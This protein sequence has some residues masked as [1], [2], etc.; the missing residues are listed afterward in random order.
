MSESNL[1]FL[2]LLLSITCLLFLLSITLIKYSIDSR[3][4]DRNLKVY[5]SDIDKLKRENQFLRNFTKKLDRSA[6]LLITS[7]GLELVKHDDIEKITGIKN[8]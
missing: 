3:T 1:Y 7:N 8:D 5:E 4:Y 6:G 2:I